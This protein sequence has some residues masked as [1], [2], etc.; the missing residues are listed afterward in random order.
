MKR[1]GEWYFKFINHPYAKLIKIE[2]V[3]A[4]LIYDLNDKTLRKLFILLLSFLKK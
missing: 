4:I 1:Y 3:I 2:I